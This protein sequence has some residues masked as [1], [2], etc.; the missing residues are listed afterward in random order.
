V[1]DDVFEEL[2]DQVRKFTSTNLERGG[3]VT[4]WVLFVA[5]S[6]IDDD[7]E[8]CWA[9]DYSVGPDTDLYLMSDETLAVWAPVDRLTQPTRQKVQRAGDRE[10]VD[11]A[12][13]WLGDVSEQQDGVCHVPTY[14]RVTADFTRRQRAT[15]ASRHCGTRPPSRCSHRR[16]RSATDRSRYGNVPSLT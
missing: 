12:Q 9:Y 16:R 5:S 10:W 6:R 4:G 2:D 1:T 13:Q 15:P 14:R 11:G 7:G 8:M 3:V